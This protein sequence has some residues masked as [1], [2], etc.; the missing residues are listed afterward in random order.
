MDMYIPLIANSRVL[1]IDAY[2][3]LREASASLLVQLYRA[4]PE[5]Q[6]VERAISMALTLFYSSTLHCEPCGTANI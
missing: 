6:R 1:P 4:I 2:H 3:I 5:P